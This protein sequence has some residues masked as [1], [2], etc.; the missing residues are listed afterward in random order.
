MRL[1]HIDIDS[2]RP[3]HL[4]CYGYH[5]NTSPTIDA[6]AARALRF[7]NCYVSDAPCLPSRTA[8][9]SGCF[10]ARTGVVGH[11]GT[12]ADPFIQGP[13]RGFRNRMLEAHWPECL[14]RRGVHT[15]AISP[16]PNRHSAMHWNAGWRE[17]HDTGLRGSE[18]VEHVAPVAHNWIEQHAHRDNWCL[19]INFWDPHTPYRTPK[20]FP[21]PFADQPTPAW[22]TES[23]RR[24][25][26]EGC[27][28][29]SAQE[30]NGFDPEGW[31]KPGE[32]PAQP[33]QM[34]DMAAVRAMFDGYDTAVRYVDDQIARLFEHLASRGVLDETAIVITAD[35]GENLGELNIYGDHQ[36]ADHITC[37]VPFILH[38]P[39]VTEALAG[40]AAGGL[41]YQFDLG[42][43]LLD[44]FGAAVP[45]HWDGRSLA[46]PIRAG[47]LPAGREFLVL[48][49]QAWSCQR[50]VRWGDHLAIR[51][52]HDG[53][54]GFPETML[55][56][57]A[58]DPHEQ[59]DLAGKDPVLVAE[60]M[61]MLDGWTTE[62]ARGGFGGVDPMWTVLREGGPFHCRGYLRAYV[63]RL[64]ATGRA[65]WADHL[66]GRYPHEL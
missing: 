22:L 46:G 16:F 63:D 64:R 20:S 1:L 9:V 65:G 24:R 44:L 27:G 38:W 15:A 34:V 53:Y 28:P 33:R 25:H 43:T 6:L 4:G 8:F 39:G 30:V 66:A 60:A 18:T 11:G 37:R 17:L 52:Y 42:A 62:V 49:N 55:F 2:L 32:Y 61:R 59:T 36:T 41:H 14:A 56:D 35:H 40:Q 13:T 12:A 57:V 3:D 45:P 31:L 5:R 51:S 7:T 19:F 50:S 48:S 58:R 10:G 21:N 26:W 47:S 23:V 54:H 29:H